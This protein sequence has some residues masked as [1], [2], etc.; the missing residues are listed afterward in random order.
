ME[1]IHFLDK[2]EAP[3][4]LPHYSLSFIQDY[5]VQLHTLSQD[6]LRPK[7]VAQPPFARY[8]QSQ[9]P[10]KSHVTLVKPRFKRSASHKRRRPDVWLME[11]P[12]LPWL[13]TFYWNVS[14]KRILCRTWCIFRGS[15]LE[16]WRLSKPSPQIT[17]FTQLPTLL[18]VKR[19]WCLKWRK[20]NF[21]WG[22]ALRNWRGWVLP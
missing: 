13:F 6:W 9:P 12:A 17:P 1:Y 8:S 11:S 14:L 18:G 20:A 21:M 2:N 3:V 16:G 15:I 4:F 5:C 19:K 22:V 10:L 7:A